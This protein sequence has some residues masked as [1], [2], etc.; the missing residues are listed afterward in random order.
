MRE[1]KGK[2]QRDN[3]RERKLDREKNIERKKKERGKTKLVL[4]PL[5]FPILHCM[6]VTTLKIP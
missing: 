5:F 6:T 3:E 1:R 4:N 2:R